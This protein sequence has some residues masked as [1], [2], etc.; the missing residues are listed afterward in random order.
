MKRTLLLIAALLFF[1]CTETIE[2]TGGIYGVITDKATGEPVRSAGVQLNTGNKTITGSE[3]Q[4]EFAELKAG[5][6]TLLVTKTGYT[7]L[8]G[9]KINVEAGKTVKGD[10]Q[11]EKLPA[12]LRIVNDNRED[13]DKLDFGNAESDITRSFNIFNDSPASLEWEITKTAAWI[14]NI[15]KTN[16]NLNAGMTQGIIITINRDALSD[17]QNTTT[18]HVTSDNGNK[19]LTV[20][21]SKGGA[22]GNDYVVLQSDGIMVQKYDISS[23]T[24]WD[25]AKKLCAASNVGGYNDWR[26]PTFGE[27]RT[28]YN[29]R[30]EIGEFSTVYSASLYWSSTAYWC[31]D[32]YNGND[33]YYSNSNTTNRVRAV[34]TLP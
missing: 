16:G 19:A 32:F 1:S 2:K 31:I 22:S 24:T 12:A 18:V 3:G 11:I 30:S 13:I 15:S 20:T 14:S 28:L 26:V 29:K 5:E 34:R 25:N 7:D 27:L 10:V 17:G 21:A 8:V 4:Y 23:G 6:Y 33:N 9:Y